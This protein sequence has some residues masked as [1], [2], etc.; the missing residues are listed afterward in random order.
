MHLNWIEEGFG[1]VRLGM[2][3][4]LSF[5]WEKELASMFSYNAR[6]F[7]DDIIR[8]SVTWQI[9]PLKKK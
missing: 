1:L 9:V 4:T 7:E 6:G 2:K 8:L 3:A 5:V